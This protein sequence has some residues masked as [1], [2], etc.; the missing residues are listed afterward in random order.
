M[1]SLQRL[2]QQE[3]NW[4][5]LDDVKAIFNRQGWE[6]CLLEHGAELRGHRLVWRKDAEASQKKRV[7]SAQR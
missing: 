6:Q 2:S 4:G 3:H 1:R 5:L 7:R